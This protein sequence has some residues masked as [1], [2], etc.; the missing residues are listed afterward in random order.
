M[1]E[2]DGLITHEEDENTVLA[3][4]PYSMK[5]L[6]QELHTMSIAPRLIT[7]EQIE[8]PVLLDELINNFK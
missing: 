5:L 4:I 1:N 2:K 6:L 3:K 8:N 7:N